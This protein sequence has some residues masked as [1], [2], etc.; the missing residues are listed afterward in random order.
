MSA[1][2]V[3]VTDNKV[4]RGAGCGLEI[5]C[6]YLFFDEI[7]TLRNL[8]LLARTKRELFF[9]FLLKCHC[10]GHV[11]HYMSMHTTAIHRLLLFYG[12]SVGME[13]TF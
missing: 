13:S 2:L 9:S 5:P 3:E 7:Y 10:V 8:K 4:N 12:Q 6:K 1:L 11:V